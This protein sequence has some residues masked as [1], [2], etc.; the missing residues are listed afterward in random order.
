MAGISATTFQLVVYLNLCVVTVHIVHICFH[1]PHF[2]SLSNVRT[3]VPAPG[4]RYLLHVR[5]HPSDGLPVH[6]QS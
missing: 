1:L 4:I 6:V 3:S 2:F 5:L